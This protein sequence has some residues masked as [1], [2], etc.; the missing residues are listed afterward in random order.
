V[1]PLPSNTALRPLAGG[2]LII[3]LLGL[4]CPLRALAEVTPPALMERVDAV[5]PPDALALGEGANVVLRVTIDEGGKVS[6][7]EVTQSGGPRF[8]AA[9]T[10]AVMQWTFT[11]AQRDGKPVKSRITIPFTFEPP[12]VTVQ[13]AVTPPPPRPA[14]IAVARALEP[15]PQAA[16]PPP[17]VREAPADVV[18]VSVRG[19]RSPPPRATSD[20]VLNREVLTVAP[21][22]GAAEM[23]MSAP[24]VY[25]AQAEGEAVAHEIQL[26]G[27][28]A[29]HGQDI[30][31]TAGVVPV[32]L[33]SH[34][35][36]QGYADLNFIIPEVVRS[37]RV[38]EGVYDPRQ[39]DFAVAGSIHFDLGVVERGWQIKTS[40][41]T[42]GTARQLVLW[43]PAGMPEET[44]GAVVI[45]RSQGFGM[46]RG[47]MSGTGMGQMVWEA[48]LGFRATLHASAAGAR[49]GLAGVLRYD[50]LN[51]G[52]VN[53]YDSYPDP[54]ANAQNALST[55]AQSAVTL[56]RTSGDGART[57]F[58][59]WG[60][61]STFRLKENFTGYLQRS[62]Q[63]PQWVG[64]GDL[65]EQYHQ[66]LAGG[67]RASHRTAR[68]APFSWLSAHFEGGTTLRVDIMEQQQNL[69]AA[70]QNE[71][72]D[73]RVDADIKG[74]D[75]G[76]YLDADIRITRFLRLRGGPRVD[77]L[78]YDVDDKLGN[79]IPSVQRQTHIV[80]YR[81]TA[82]GMAFGP[83]GS[84]EVTPFSWLG[85]QAAYGEG[86]RS[87]QA[88]ILEDGENA[89][90]TKVRSGEVGFRLTPGGSDRFSLSGA[91]F[92]TLLS[93][94]LAFDPGEGRLETVG[95]TSRKGLASQLL[96]HPW[97]WLLTSLSVTYV[98]ATLDAP[99]PAT[100]ENP[101]PPYRR[102]Q[103]L[104]YV[105]PLVVR[106]DVGLQ[107]DFG[108]LRNSPLTARVG[109]G[110]SFLSPR[111]LPY[112]KLAEPVFLVDCSASLRTRNLEIGME[113]FNLFNQRYAAT[114]YSFVSNWATREV[115]SSLPARHF[116]AGSPRTVMLVLGVHI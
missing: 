99:P 81:R 108:M 4:L 28:D 102:G 72:W 44:F 14:P 3:I 106:G 87:P 83:R 98:N 76:L 19:R 84:I 46:N 56:E 6:G 12:P 29:E 24:G 53:F 50:D 20:Y 32:N 79:F 45:K 18:D 68:I 48:P 11:P 97:S 2:A 51:A 65:I 93:Q 67:A 8:D 40:L 17:P 70:P 64:R 35:H 82:L 21:H 74:A 71:T 23:L 33:P 47:S 116:S 55:R 115:P 86:Y 43:A 1:N 26:R 100:A 9:A 110:F 30:E 36:G 34:I 59:L 114:E 39:G 104:P 113:I 75:I 92:V 77:V 78:Y 42:F 112:G 89:P 22:Q 27:F 94:D 109:A 103:L 60:L 31:L 69:V 66:D 95:P 107:K 101:N 80:G 52:L 105:P 63:R 96:V 10:G 90:Y 13:K 5:Y 25:V 88:R 7:V 58:S 37:V 49:A 54:T 61:F 16:P 57:E 41:G 85:F 91:A 62:Q 38:T 73:Q 15:A 111:P